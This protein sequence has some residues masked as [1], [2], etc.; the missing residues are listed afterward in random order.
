MLC[1]ALPP[2]YA[3]TCA[4]LLDKEKSVLTVDRVTK[5]VLAEEVN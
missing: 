1:N 3:T 2:S 5:S 4:I